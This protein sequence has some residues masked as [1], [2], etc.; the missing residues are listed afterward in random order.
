LEDAMLADMED[1][2]LA[3]LAAL[4]AV[5][6]AALRSPASAPRDVSAAQSAE[7]DATTPAGTELLPALLVRLPRELLLP[8][9]SLRSEEPALS[10]SPELAALASSSLAVLEDA[11]LA[12]PPAVLEDAMLAVMEDAVLAVLAALHA[13]PPAALRSP[14]SAPRDVSAAQSAELDATTPAGTELLPALLVR[15][16]RELLLPL[17]SLRSEE[18]AL[19]V[20]PELAVLASFN[21]AVLEDATLV[22]PPAVM[23]DAVPAVMEDVVPAVS[24]ATLAVLAALHA[25]PPAVPLSPASAPRDVSAAQFAALDATTPAVTELLPALLVRLPR[26]LLVP[27]AS[28]RSEEPALSVSPELAVLASSSRAADVPVSAAP[29]PRR[30]LPA[31]L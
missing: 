16:P 19:S 27:L 11:T 20:S 13:V 24:D 7:L 30:E 17:A 1:A 23:E 6:P 3:V 29:D 14:A 10:V 28:L 31:R 8:L 5:P 22:A 15:L 21:P 4:H 12:A 2:M 9:A 18:P 26:E 25:V